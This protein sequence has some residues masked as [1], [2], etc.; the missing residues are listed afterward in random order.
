[1]ETTITYT[2]NLWDILHLKGIIDVLRI[3][4]PS[5]ADQ[6]LLKM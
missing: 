4:N 3:T 6:L 2:N 1:M 5:T